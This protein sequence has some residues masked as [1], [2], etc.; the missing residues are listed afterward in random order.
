S[1]PD[2]C[3]IIDYTQE[4]TGRMEGA[5][6]CMTLVGAYRI[7]TPLPVA[8]LILALMAVATS[9]A[10]SLRQN[11]KTIAAAVLFILSGLCLAVG[12]IL[13]ISAIS[14]ELGYQK[15]TRLS[16]FQYRYGWSFYTAGSAFISA[17]VAAVMC[18][19]LY[20]RHN[21]RVQDM[22]RIIPGLEA[23]LVEDRCNLEADKPQDDLQDVFW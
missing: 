11:A 22:V 3:L 9:A 5:P 7:A 21:A 15:M 6:T 18:V 14:D 1:I 10:G 13:F 4:G 20:L 2:Q 23:K 12:V 19:T 16:D 17:E 8:A